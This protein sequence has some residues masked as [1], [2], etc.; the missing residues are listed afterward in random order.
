MNPVLLVPL[1][2]RSILA[3]FW[4]QKFQQFKKLPTLFLNFDFFLDFFFRSSESHFSTKNSFII[5]LIFLTAELVLSLVFRS[6]PFITPR[7]K[8]RHKFEKKI[9]EFL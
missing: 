2:V 8:E 9:V 4:N 5:Y 1:V 6:A 7:Q 3:P